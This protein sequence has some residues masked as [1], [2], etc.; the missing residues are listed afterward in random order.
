MLNSPEIEAHTGVA[1]RTIRQWIEDGV[2]PQTD[3][4]G[5]VV[6]SI[7]TYYKGQTAEARRDRTKE[8]RDKLY[9]S[10]VRL[11]EAQAEK[12]ELE[13]TLRQGKLV[14]ADAVVL[15]WSGYIASCK[16][17]LLGLPTRLALELAGVSDPKLVQQ[18]IQESIDQ[19]LLELSNERFVQR[20]ESA[21]NSDSN[22]S[23]ST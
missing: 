3:D 15:A 6:K 14:E 12:L 5:L 16:A 13:N 7:I 17:L 18:M 11:S 19:A 8:G 9:V 20:L 10:K 22:F 23:A 4:M 21:A 2:I 1:Q